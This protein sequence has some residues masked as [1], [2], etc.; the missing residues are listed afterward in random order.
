MAEER[1]TSR[2]TGQQ[3]DDAVDAVGGKADVISIGSGTKKLP[4]SQL[5]WV[6][7]YN[8]EAIAS[9]DSNNKLWFCTDGHLYYRKDGSISADGKDFDMGTPAYI[10][11]YSGNK[12]Y[13][14]SG[15]GFEEMTNG[16]LAN[17]INNLTTGGT[18]KA[19]SAEQG[20]VLKAKI[21]EVY[22]ALQSVYNA[23]GNA[24][25][26]GS[27]PAT[28]TILPDLDWSVSKHT[29]SVTNSIGSSKASIT[30]LNAEVSSTQIEEGATFQLKVTGK[31]GWAITRV[32]VSGATAII[33]EGSG[34]NAGVWTLQMTMGTSNMSITILGTAIKEVNVSKTLTGCEVVANSETY[35]VVTGSAYSVTIKPTGS[36]TFT[37]VTATMDNNGSSVNL[38]QETNN[39]G[40]KT[41]STQS[42]TGDITIV[43]T[44][45]GVMVKNKVY[46]ESTGGDMVSDGGL[47]AQCNSN[48]ID[49]EGYSRFL[50]VFGAKDTTP[51]QFGLVLYDSSKQRIGYQNAN[52]RNGYR[53]FTLSSV[54]DLSGTPKYARCSFWLTSRYESVSAD[55][56]YN[57]QRPNFGRGEPPYYGAGLW[58]WTDDDGGKW[59]LIFDASNDVGIE[60]QQS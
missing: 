23:L 48:Y 13:K 33:T 52:N 15:S 3:I 27:K 57:P 9:C 51:S 11:Y 49:I 19:L 59:E 7:L 55:N 29:L 43:A 17:I 37:D 5:P 20:V 32:S 40:S 38:T 60:N 47:G 34:A 31:N 58:G 18:D 53:D 21:N 50:Y 44:A 28:S 54:Q 24:A 46:K 14:W 45:A 10:L 56:P 8:L 36:N 1:Y 42:V 6:S 30:Y 41:I 25:F 35:P 22:A 4:I 26:W 39:D 12:I 16:S 2:H